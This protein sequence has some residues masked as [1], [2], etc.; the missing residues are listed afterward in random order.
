MSTTIHPNAFVD[1]L[2]QLGVGVKVG[3]FA[4]IE[5]GVQIGDHS[6]IGHHAVVHSG[7]RLGKD[8]SIFS[9]RFK[10]IRFNVPVQKTIRL[11][12]ADAHNLPGIAH[13]HLGDKELWWVLLD[14]N[15]LYDP[16][17]DVVPGLVL[18]IPSR[19]ALITYM[20]TTAD[21]PGNLIL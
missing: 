1:P 17:E 16:I 11:S 2:A 18:R 13:V 10:N 9:A 20:E 6:S 8:N 4:V 12:A 3:A 14:F 7:T 15:G 21:K 5:A 19:T